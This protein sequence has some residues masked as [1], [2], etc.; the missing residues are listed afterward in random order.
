MLYGPRES[1]VKKLSGRA[2][3]RELEQ[4]DVGFEPNELAGRWASTCCSGRRDG[5]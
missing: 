5:R 1:Q 4:A 2:L 3:N